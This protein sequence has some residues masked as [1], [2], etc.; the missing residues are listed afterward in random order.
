MRTSTSRRTY[1]QYANCGAS[2]ETADLAPAGGGDPLVYCP[3][4]RQ[5]IQHE[6]RL[7]GGG[8]RASQVLAS[9]QD[10]RE[11]LAQTGVED[12]LKDIAALLSGARSPEHFDEYTAN[13][14]TKTGPYEVAYTTT[15]RQVVTSLRAN[16]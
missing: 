16:R 11:L 13:L 15:V 5:D 14:E 7:P 8:M 1:C 2:N 9:I 12:A 4:H 3:G 10:S 6:Y